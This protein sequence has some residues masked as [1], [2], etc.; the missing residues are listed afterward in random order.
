MFLLCRNRAIRGNR[1]QENGESIH[2]GITTRKL[3]ITYFCSDSILSVVSIQSHESIEKIRSP[4]KH[5]RHPF[6]YLLRNQYNTHSH[7]G[8]RI[9]SITSA[10]P[11]PKTRIRPI[12]INTSD[13]P[14]LFF[15]RPSSTILELFHPVFFTATLRSSSSADSQRSILSISRR[16]SQVSL[17]GSDNT[18]TGPTPSLSASL[19]HLSRLPKLCTPANSDLSSR[20]IPNCPPASFNFSALRRSFKTAFASCNV[21]SFD[22]AYN[23]FDD[24]LERGIQS[25]PSSFPSYRYRAIVSRYFIAIHRRNL[26]S[27][28]SSAISLLA[29]KKTRDLIMILNSKSLFLPPSTLTSSP[30]SV[31]QRHPLALESLNRHHHDMLQRL[32]NRVFEFVHVKTQG[33][34]LVN[35]FFVGDITFL[36]ISAQ[37]QQAMQVLEVCFKGQMDWRRENWV[38]MSD[39]NSL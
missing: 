36:W 16:P 20:R 5:N 14:R 18:P 35:F 31:N 22:I 11:T 21:F 9:D 19:C 2:T 26:H 27:N 13:P 37:L 24:M 33:L 29:N 23:M 8:A 39:L 28:V 32:W 34:L 30:H 38:K 15:H 10:R 12:P 25:Q 4:I 1:L 7:F 17:G 3:N 6:V